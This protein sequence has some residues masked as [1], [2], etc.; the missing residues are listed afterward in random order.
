[1]TMGGTGPEVLVTLTTDYGK[2]LQGLHSTKIKG[3]TH[4][5]TGIQV[6]GV[7]QLHRLSLVGMS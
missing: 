4:L 1:M 3:G 6:A 2:I 7:R 5:A